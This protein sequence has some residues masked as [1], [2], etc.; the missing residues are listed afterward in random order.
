[1]IQ[2]LPH[3]KE[4]T[5]L[6]LLRHA[7]TS[8]NAEGR[9]QGN[10]DNPLNEAGIS[11]ATKLAERMARQYDLDKI[12]ASPYIRARQTAQIVADACHMDVETNDDLVEVNFGDIANHKFKDLEQTHP[13][14]FKQIRLFFDSHPN[15]TM[16][17]PQTPNGETM[18]AIG[19]RA[20]RFTNLLLDKYNGQRVALV[21]HG[22]FMKY[23]LASYAGMPLNKP[24]MIWL[25]NASLS[26]VDFYKGK[27]IIRVINDTG[28][29]D[30]PLNYARP[31]LM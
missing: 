20:A 11:Q 23:M 9:I 28:H 4:Y 25:D 30:M 24:I 19:E 12:F 27:A 17:R 2:K 18:Q 5:R 10:V 6:F 16:E 3:N 13:E 7:Q 29:L 31:G 26:V 21:S 1:M 22:A 15:G 8:M 14:F